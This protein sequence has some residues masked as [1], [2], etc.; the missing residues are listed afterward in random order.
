MPIHSCV[1]WSPRCFWSTSHQTRRASSHWT[2]WRLLLTSFGHPKVEREKLSH[3]VKSFELQAP[4][5]HKKSRT[6]FAEPLLALQNCLFRKAQL[7]LFLQALIIGQQSR[8]H[9]DVL[10][11]A[12]KYVHH[13]RSGSEPLPTNG[14]RCSL[15]GSEVFRSLYP[16]KNYTQGHHQY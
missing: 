2:G 1:A 9:F 16:T 11:D 13:G 12:Q 4:K 5:A 15:A 8:L 7:P 10:N 3:P 6:P 14:A